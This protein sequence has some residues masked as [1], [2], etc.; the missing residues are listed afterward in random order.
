MKKLRI[1][2]LIA[3]LGAAAASCNFG[4]GHT[5][6]IENDNN[7]YLK[8]E[9][10][11]HVH[12]SDDGTAI[13]SISRGGYVK[14]QYN[15]RKLEARNNGNNGVSY[16]LYDNGEKLDPFHNGRPLIAEAVKMMIRKGYH[17]ERK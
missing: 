13:S 6:I 4:R 10:S 9:Y 15:N 5:T 7:N 17:P 3:V 16:E 1:L 2:L 11:G 14:Y 12:F 8:I